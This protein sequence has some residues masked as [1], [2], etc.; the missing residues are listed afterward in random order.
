MNEWQVEE[1]RRT[2]EAA[3]C[4]PATDFVEHSQVTAWL[5]SWGSEEEGEPPR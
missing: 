1:I 3:D 5:G 4:A 2:L